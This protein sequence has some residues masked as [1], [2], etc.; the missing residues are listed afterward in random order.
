MADARKAFRGNARQGFNDD[1]LK[2]DEV[3]DSFAEAVP[4]LLSLRRE[5][6]AF[7]RFAASQEW[8]ALFDNDTAV[9]TQQFQLLYGEHHGA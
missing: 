1:D 7:I 9:F 5:V 8:D 3:V 4:H 6:D 2:K